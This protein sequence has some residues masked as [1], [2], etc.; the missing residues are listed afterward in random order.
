M[1]VP[2]KL[3]TSIERK[4]ILWRTIKCCIWKFRLAHITAFSWY[5]YYIS[6]LILILLA[7]V[8]DLISVVSGSAP[9]TTPGLFPACWCQWTIAAT[10]TTNGVT[11]VL[12]K[13][14]ARTE[15]RWWGSSRWE[16]NLPYTFHTPT[17]IYLHIYRYTEDYRKRPKTH[18]AA[19]SPSS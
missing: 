11:A 18:K 1:I 2:L 10:I 12:A 5:I 13:R 8:P 6:M 16:P 15:K 17:Y 7:T 19:L 4:P 9:S 14:K 3:S